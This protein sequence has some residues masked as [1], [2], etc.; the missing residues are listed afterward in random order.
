[1]IFTNGFSDF[2]HIHWLILLYII[3]V[4]ISISPFGEFVLV[5]L[6]GGRNIKRTDMKIKIIPLVELVYDKAKKEAPNMVKSVNIKVIYDSFPNAYAIGRKTICVTSGLFNLTDEEIMGILAHEFGHI[7]NRHSELQLIIGG[8]N[9]FVI[10]FLFM[11]KVF[12]NLIVAICTI[13]AVNSING[14]IFFILFIFFFIFSY[15][16]LFCIN[17]CNLCM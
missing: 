6:A 12:S 8:L 16:M 3:S 9:I 13:L 14:F 4:F 15:I 2:T 11:L 1:M 17:V 10:V 7:A 5:F